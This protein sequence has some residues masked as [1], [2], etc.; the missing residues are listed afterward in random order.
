MLF[1]SKEDTTNIIPFSA[2]SPFQNQYRLNIAA[3]EVYYRADKVRGNL[4]MQFGDAPNLLA[5]PKQEFVKYIR[6]ANFG[7]RI[8]KNLWIDMGFMFTPI[9]YE[10]TWPVLNQLTSVT[11]GG[12]FEP[13][14]ILGI[15]LSYKFSE[16]F[17]GGII[18]G[19]P[20]SLAYD[21]NTNGSIQLTF[22]YKPI[23]QLSINYNN[24]IDN[25]ALKDAQVN[26]YLLYNNLIVTYDPTSHI[27]LVGQLDFA[28]QTQ[29]QRKPDTT[30]TATMFSG[31]LQASYIFNSHWA[32]TG[33]YE[34]FND[35]DGF[36]SGT[37]TYNNTTTGL[38][39]YGCTFGFEYKPLK[40]AY[41]RAEYRY[42]QANPLNPV[43]HGSRT[44]NM[45]DILFC[46]GLRF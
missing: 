36:L 42:M 7:L 28:A 32:I 4:V 8:A 23:P 21:Q 40:I 38:L 6:Q 43:F 3:F 33:R 46:A 37:Y 34:F 14:S 24:M 20:Y 25:Q 13:G 30:E 5:S 27:K 26:H 15:K 31:F 41:L 17:S 45:N 29:S 2:N 18:F 22:T 16:K 10:S 39:L 35:P 44:S 1:D 9:G 11:S 12:Y 19:N